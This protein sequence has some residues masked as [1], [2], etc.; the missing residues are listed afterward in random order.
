MGGWKANPGS[1]K[2][3]FNPKPSKGGFEFLEKGFEVNSKKTQNK[4]RIIFW[5]P[6]TLKWNFD[7]VMA[8]LFAIKY[9]KND[10]INIHNKI[11]P[12]WFPHSPDIL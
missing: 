9:I 5:I 11:D 3:G 6:K 2:R 1:C 10:N 12:S 8:L 4:K 7:D